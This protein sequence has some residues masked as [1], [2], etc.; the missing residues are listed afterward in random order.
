MFRYFCKPE[1]RTRNVE[2]AAAMQFQTFSTN[3]RVTD[4]HCHCY[5][6][7]NK[8]VYYV[9]QLFIENTITSTIAPKTYKSSANC[10]I[11]N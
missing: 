10:A 9:N 4:Y 8:K 2:N 7:K 6:N 3:P 1:V 5:G 11:S